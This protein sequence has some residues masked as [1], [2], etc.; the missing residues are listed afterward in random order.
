MIKFDAEV[1]VPH[2]PDRVWAYVGDLRREPEYSPMTVH[3][4]LETCEPIAIGTRFRQV[5]VLKGRQF[6]HHVEVTEYE[7]AHK[8]AYETRGARFPIMWS[9][10]L[11]RT[12]GGTR[13][14]YGTRARPGDAGGLRKLV[15][16]LLSRMIRSNAKQEIRR[17][18]ELLDCG[19]A[20]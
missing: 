12:H 5:G 9:Y 3:A 20:D 6:V 13:V 14:H 19:T 2:P 7:P 4:E 11:H 1:E 10:T 15:E 16:P 17:L 8:V 18:V